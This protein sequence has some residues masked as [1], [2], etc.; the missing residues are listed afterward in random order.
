M[1]SSQYNLSSSC[2]NRTTLSCCQLIRVSEMRVSSVHLSQYCL[3][4]SIFTLISFCCSKKLLG[5]LYLT[6][7]A[8]STN[9]CK[10]WW[11]PW[12]FRIR[13][14]HKP[15]MFT[16][17]HF[18]L[19]DLFL[20]LTLYSSALYDLTDLPDYYL[21]R[22]SNSSANPGITILRQAQRL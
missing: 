13:K 5:H 7:T 6:R 1:K 10:R 19:P 17:N 15:F 9:L 20:L 3:F 8:N 12:L 18:H 21:R 2:L 14:V 16:S 4:S 22:K 11:P